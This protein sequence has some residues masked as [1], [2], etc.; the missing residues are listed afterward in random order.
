M[1]EKVR[2]L[3]ELCFHDTPAFTDLYFRMRYNNE[4]NL[5]IQSGDTVIAAMQMLPYPMT[6]CGRTINTA[7]I[8]GACTHPDFR[9]KGIMRELLTEAFGRMHTQG[10]LLSTLIPAEP[11]LFDYY[12][13][14]GYAPVFNVRTTTFRATPAAGLPPE[15]QVTS[16]NDFTPQLYAYFEQKMRQRPCCI[17]HTTEDFKVILADLQLSDGHIHLLHHA[18]RNE[19][20]ALA[21]AYPDEKGSLLI[22]EL[23]ADSK[24]EARLLLQHICQT[25]GQTELRLLRPVSENEKGERLGMGR[26]INAYTLLQLYATA[27][28]DVEWNLALTDKQLQANTGYYYLNNG[29]CMKSAKR[30]PGSHLALTIGELTEKIATPLHPYMSLML[31]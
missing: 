29:H 19:V 28:P 15:Y 27:H 1:K 6:F 12:A 9:D 24:E 18:Q 13:R 25:N 7:Y 26:I 3:W 8:S 4:V 2:E 5:A 31:N 11:W 10:I 16:T 30:L 22:G 20:T 21:F 17:Q 14:S 23:L